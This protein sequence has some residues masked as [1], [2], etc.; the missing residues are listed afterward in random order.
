MSPQIALTPENLGDY[1]RSVGFVPRNE[2]VA[3]ELNNNSEDCQ[4]G[5]ASFRERRDPVWKGY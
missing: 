1:L 2:A 5:I 4:E 3:V